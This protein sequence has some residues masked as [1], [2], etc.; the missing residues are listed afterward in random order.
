[1]T[2]PCH[3]PPV[4]VT[5]PAPATQPRDPPVQADEDVVEIDVARG[6]QEGPS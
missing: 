4:D 3:G 1:M 6:G 5:G 2:D